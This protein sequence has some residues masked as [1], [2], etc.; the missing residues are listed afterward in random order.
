MKENIMRDKII[1][2]T[3]GILVWWVL[4]YSYSYFIWDKSKEVLGWWNPWTRQMWN[5]DAS[6][7]SDEQLERMATRAWITTDELKDKLEAGES[8][9]DIMPQRTGS[10]AGIEWRRNQNT[11]TW[12]WS[13]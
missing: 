4:V 3:L 2:F 11:L 12:T 1:S 8:L 13:N 9:R 10:W 5:F 7:M 6:S